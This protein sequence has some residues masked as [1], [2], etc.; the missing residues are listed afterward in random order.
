[1]HQIIIPEKMRM[2]LLGIIH[3]GHQGQKKCLWRAK[4]AVYWPGMENDI[5]HLTERCEICQE[6]SGKQRALPLRQHDVPPYA[7]HTLGTDLFH[8]RHQDFIVIGDYYSKFLIV[9]KLSGTSTNSTIRELENI[10][11]EWGRP[12]VLKSDNGPNY[13]SREFQTFM[14]QHGIIHITSSPHHPQS[15]GFAEAMVKIS[16]KL[17]ERSTRDGKPWNAGLLEY[18]TTP[19]SNTLPSPLEILTGRKPRGRLPQMQRNFH[20][21]PKQQWIREELQERQAGQAN[22]QRRPG[23]ITDLLVGQPVWIMEPDGKSWK[24][25]QIMEILPHDSY[26]IAYPD[27][28]QLRRTR[29]MLKPRCSEEEAY[30]E[31]DWKAAARAAQD[32]TIPPSSTN[33]RAVPQTPMKSPAAMPRRSTRSTAEP[34][35]L[36][37]SKLG[38]D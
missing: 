27:G 7:W 4:D 20:T 5:I 10:F 1:M 8:W 22:Q 34:S 14:E 2:E 18:R 30:K 11:A 21:D 25:G 38:G 13:A 37:Y 26:I 6:T 35:R 29:A 23:S 12:T 3:E 9:R 24:A 33:V 15:N 28:Q 36:E 16:K 17:M 32:G 19:I 31:H